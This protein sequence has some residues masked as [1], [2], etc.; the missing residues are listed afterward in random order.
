MKKKR[1]ALVVIGVIVILLAINFFVNFFEFSIATFP[2]LCYNILNFEKKDKT[3]LLCGVW[4]EEANKHA[5]V[6]KLHAIV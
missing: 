6:E 1:I 3:I 5:A 2:L 4:G